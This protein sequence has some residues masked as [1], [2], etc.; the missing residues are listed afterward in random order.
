M[1]SNEWNDENP[2]LEVPAWLKYSLQSA[3]EQ[4]SSSFGSDSS[5]EEKLDQNTREN[6][7]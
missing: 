3:A 1:L 5:Q 7:K 4:E 2:E 6:A